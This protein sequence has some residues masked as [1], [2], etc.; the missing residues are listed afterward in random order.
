MKVCF[1]GHRKVPNEEQLKIRLTE[2]ISNLIADGADTFL[3]GSRSDFDDLCWEVVTELKEQ[4]PNIKRIA[5]TVFHELALTS[6][7][8][9][10]SCERILSN[11]MGKEMHLEIYESAVDSKKAKRATK[12]AYLMRNQEMIDDSDVCVFYYDKNYLPPKEKRGRLF[13][14]DYQPKSGTAQAFAYAQ[15]KN[16]KIINMAEDSSL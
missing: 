12:D 10:Q 9:R 11:V 4:Y 1:I 7:E 8:E 3:F 13:V 5:C 15:R 14:V 16:K 6:E 2:T